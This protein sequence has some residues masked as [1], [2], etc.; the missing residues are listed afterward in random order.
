MSAQSM[1]GAAYPSSA[2][3]DAP[4]TSTA[5]LATSREA[6]VFAGLVEYARPAATSRFQLAAAAP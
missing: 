4:A 6:T 5:E 3:A 2:A 1:V